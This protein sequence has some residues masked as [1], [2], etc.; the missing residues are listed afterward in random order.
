MIAVISVVAFGAVMAVLVA[1]F[2]A[3]RAR[4]RR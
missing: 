3:E 1:G 2:E 4:W